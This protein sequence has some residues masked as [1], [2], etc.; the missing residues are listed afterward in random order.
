MIK[1]YKYADLKDP[2]IKEKVFRSLQ[3]DWDSVLV[4]GMPYEEAMKMIK[5]KYG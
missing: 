2:K 4:F 3:R 1:G 5:E